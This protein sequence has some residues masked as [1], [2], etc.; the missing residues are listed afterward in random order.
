MTDKIELAGG[1][2]LVEVVEHKVTKFG[3]YEFFELKTGVQDLTEAESQSK[4]EYA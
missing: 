2:L 1:C 4:N 3:W